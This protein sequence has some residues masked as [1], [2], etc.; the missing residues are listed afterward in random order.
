MYPARAAW[1][2]IRRES[3]I[4]YRFCAGELSSFECCFCVRFGSDAGNVTL[5]RG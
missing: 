3:P 5:F 4:R 2:P 1:I